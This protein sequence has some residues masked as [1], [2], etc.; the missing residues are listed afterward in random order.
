MQKFFKLFS[1]QLQNGKWLPKYLVTTIDDSMVL[2]DHS[3]QFDKQFD[4]KEEAD[5]YAADYCYKKGYT[6]F[7]KK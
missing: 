7:N 6:L 4:S 3:E 1:E 2:N 5:K